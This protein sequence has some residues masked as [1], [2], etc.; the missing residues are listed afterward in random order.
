MFGSRKV[1]GLDRSA[2]NRRI[3]DLLEHRLGI[4][5]DEIA[6]PHFPGVLAFARY[7]D[8][9]WHNQMCPDWTASALAVSYVIGCSQNGGDGV[10]E[11]RRLLGT[12]ATFLSDLEHSGKIPEDKRQS[13]IAALGQCAQDLDSPRE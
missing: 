13:M 6:N 3:R 4:E 10:N 8:T 1:D 11:A 9:G 7:L 12:V 5:T 2:Y